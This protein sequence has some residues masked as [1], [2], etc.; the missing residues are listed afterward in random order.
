MRKSLIK[1]T[2]NISPDISPTQPPN[3][4]QE[5]ITELSHFKMFYIMYDGTWPGAFFCVIT[6]SPIF[7]LVVLTFTLFTNQRTS[8]IHRNSLLMFALLTSVILNKIL[9]SIFRHPRPSPHY[10]GHGMPSDHAQFM[11]L[12]VGYFTQLLSDYKRF[13]WSPRYTMTKHQEL[14][15]LLWTWAIIVIYSR[16]YLLFHTWP[17]LIAGSCVGLVLAKF[18]YYVDKRLIYDT[19]CEIISII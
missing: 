7:I 4:E 8:S 17:Q 12:F 15:A 13:N 16:Y 19:N 2:R 18:W 1:F 5:E 9:K 14:I 11:T 10:H 3:M 6:M